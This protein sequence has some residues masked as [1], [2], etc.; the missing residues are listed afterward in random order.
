L[1][2]RG[3][4]RAKLVVAWTIKH[5]IKY[6][7]GPVGGELQLAILEKRNEK[8]EARYEDSGETEQQVDALKKYISEF[9][10]QQKPAATLLA[11][12]D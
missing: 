11:A 8:W 10:K 3:S 2:C 7:P 5:A 9:G 6:N 12:A 4:E 1:K